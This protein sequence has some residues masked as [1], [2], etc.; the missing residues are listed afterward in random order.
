MCEKAFNLALFQINKQ[1]ME[2]G[3]YATHVNLITLQPVVGSDYLQ[4]SRR[5]WRNLLATAAFHGG[6]ASPQ[7]LS[8]GGIGHLQ[9]VFLVSGEFYWEQA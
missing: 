4:I 5:R 2:G 9:E 7:S 1:H 3:G 8:Y 6:T